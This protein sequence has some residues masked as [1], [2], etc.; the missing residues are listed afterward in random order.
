[1]SI[2]TTAHIMLCTLLISLNSE[3]S[4]EKVPVEM[5]SWKV[6]FFVL[7]LYVVHFPGMVATAVMS[8]ERRNCCE[9]LQ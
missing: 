3:G 8:M 6:N 7:S 2:Q 1:M 9:Y 5:F 4:L